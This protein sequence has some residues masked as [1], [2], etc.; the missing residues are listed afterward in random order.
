MRLGF[1][2]LAVILVIVLLVFGPKQIP[3]L[4]SAVNDSAKK[5]KDEFK[6]TETNTTE[7]M[8]STTKN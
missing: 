7:T 4:T 1:L 2:E 3:K 8:E 5:F 6:K